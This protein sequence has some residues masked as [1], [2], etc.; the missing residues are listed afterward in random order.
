MAFAV[1]FAH[2]LGEV[3][4]PV[5]SKLRGLLSEVGATLET[6]PRTSAVWESVALGGM[7]I[8]IEGW[9]FQYRVNAD[10]REIIVEQVKWMG[11]R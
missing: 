9:R 5:L 8:E 3:P 4:A 7:L 2:S 1:S 11:G 10:A 6:I